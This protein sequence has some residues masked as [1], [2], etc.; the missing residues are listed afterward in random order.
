M[1]FWQSHQRGVLPTWVLPAFLITYGLA[2]VGLYTQE[3]FSTN[4]IGA[5]GAGVI[6]VSLVFFNKVT[7]CYWLSI[8]GAVVGSL[9]GLA[10]ISAVGF[11]SPVGL[12]G[13]VYIGYSVFWPFYFRAYLP[14]KQSIQTTM[15]G[16]AMERSSSS[17][18]GVVEEV[19]KVGTETANLTDESVA[20]YYATE[21]NLF[22]QGDLIEDLWAKHLVMCE[23]DT[24]KAKWSYIKEKAR[25]TADAEDQKKRF[26]GELV[27]KQLAEI[28]GLKRE[29]NAAQAR[30]LAE[31]AFAIF[32]VFFIFIIIFGIARG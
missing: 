32:G 7:W 9:G 24:E 16:A 20:G 17:S 28:E 14:A 25:L 31:V 26:E 12:L 29:A 8:F 5:L 2:F 11:N 1:G 27:K 22:E 23:G 18:Q 10:L 4:T 15:V 6:W 21:L 19:Q 13:L 3:R 30:R